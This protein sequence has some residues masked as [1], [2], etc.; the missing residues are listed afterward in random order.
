[1][2]VAFVVH[3]YGEE[4]CGGAEHHCRQVAERMVKY[5]NVEVL[6]SCAT[7]AETWAN[8]LPP[9]ATVIRGVTIRRFPV[10]H[11]RDVERMTDL[12]E[13]V[14]SGIGSWQDQIDWMVAYGP[15][16]SELFEF[17]R[18]RAD[19]YDFVIFFTYV[20]AFTVFGIPLVRGKCA[21]VPTVHDEPE[22]YIPLFQ[23]VFRNVRALLFSTSAEQTFVN[24]LFG[25][26]GVVQDV[27]GVGIEQPPDSNGERLQKSHEAELEGRVILLYAGRI[28]ERKGCGTLVS[29]FTRFCEER[30]EYP[31]KL[32]LLGAKAMD[33][34]EHPDIVY[35]GYVSEREKF[36]AFAA[37]SVIVQPSPYESL[38]MAVVEG[39]QLERPALVNSVCE[40]LR[41]QCIRS[42]GGLWYSNYEEFREELALLLADEQLAKQLGRSG[43]EYVE[44]NYAWDVVESKYLRVVARAIDE[45]PRT[46]G[47]GSGLGDLRQRWLGR[48]VLDRLDVVRGASPSAPLSAGCPDPGRARPSPA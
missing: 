25:T 17:L 33:I 18:T 38:S 40:V 3:R 5:W 19:D 35:L 36:D 13:R 46:V 11:P 7:D 37:A 29:H 21:L 48:D 16:S 2:R 1:M 22:I 31:V 39:W 34:P 15:Y 23:T 30:P 42:N 44:R 8:A 27:I 32:V 24:R 14:Y 41:D 28:N 20:Y 9:G 12:D 26:A 43:R 47:S 10:D 45:G 6:T 4:V